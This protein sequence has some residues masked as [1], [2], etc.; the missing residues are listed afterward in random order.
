MQRFPFTTYVLSVGAYL[1]LSAAVSVAQELKTAESFTLTLYQRAQLAFQQGQLAQAQEL[2]EQHLKR[3][4]PDAP[5]AHKLAGLSAFLLQRFEA[6]EKHM[7]EAARLQPQDVEPPYHLGRYYFEDK[8]YEEALR[9]FNLVAQLD[10]RH[11][12]ARYYTALVYQGQNELAQAQ[13]AYQSAI[14]LIEQQR[15]AYAWPYA[16]LGRLLVNE[17]ELERGL[18]WL[19]RGVRNDPKSPYAHYHYAKALFQQEA[20]FE[21]KAELD[22][23]LKL[24]PDYSDAWYLLARYYQK[25]GAT[26][27][28]QA[29]FVKF[30]E[31]KKKSIPSPF[32]VRR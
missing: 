24:D 27:L 8:R 18:S 32:G 11:Y 29:T 16:D 22:E 14:R 20:S 26:K 5:A 7:R 17:G 1:C 15:A 19:Y 13:E 31:V 9:A 6:F 12:K 25:T 28:A 23:A 30:E 4:Q 3:N 2:A 21:V 10:A